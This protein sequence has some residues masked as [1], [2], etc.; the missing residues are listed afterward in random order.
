MAVHGETQR[1]SVR[2]ARSAD[3]PAFR[4]EGLQREDLGAMKHLIGCADLRGY[5]CH[6][7]EGLRSA[8]VVHYAPSMIRFP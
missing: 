8:K 3:L 1:I 6:R 7:C 5:W 2:G 4:L